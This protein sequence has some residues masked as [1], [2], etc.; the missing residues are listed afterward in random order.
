LFLDD[1]AHGPYRGKPVWLDEFQ[2]LE[3]PALRSYLKLDKS[4]EGVV[5]HHPAEAD[6]DYPLKE[7]D[8]ISKIGDTPIDDQGMI[9]I[10]SELKVHFAYLLQKLVK[11]GKVPLTV[12]RGGQELKVE[13]PVRTSRP[14]LVPDLAGAYPSYFVYGPIVFSEATSEF[15][16][17]FLRDSKASNYVFA[18]S[19]VGNPLMTRAGARPAFEGERL[20]VVSSPFFPHKLSQ[21]YSSPM[22]LVVKSVN[23][24]P[25]KNL[26]HLVEVLRD[27]KDEFMTIDFATRGGETLVFRRTEILAATEEIMTD[28]GI[29]TQGSADSLTIWN[30]KKN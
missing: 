5:V 10:S 20:V 8:V 9:K 16:A 14:L 4:V 30:A 21:G 3:N 13:L 26:G 29:R 2:T 23:G 7:W 24:I 28:N 18:M 27:S 15:L 17:G 25:I 12:V 11:D 19:F 6:A 22:G 1:I